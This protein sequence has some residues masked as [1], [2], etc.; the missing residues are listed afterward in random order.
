MVAG[1]RIDL[2]TRGFSILTWR[3]R[4]PRNG[5]QWALPAAEC[6]TLH[7][8]AELIPAKLTL[9]FD[10]PALATKRCKHFVP[11]PASIARKPRSHAS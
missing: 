7:D 11:E 2:P 8:G 4:G 5:A 1:D 3:W 9:S 10:R 6:S